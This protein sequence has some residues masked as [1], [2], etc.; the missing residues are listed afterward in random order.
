MRGINAP[1]FAI[2]LSNLSLL[3]FLAHTHFKISYHVHISHYYKIKNKEPQT[4]SCSVARC[5][6]SITA[7]S[8]CV[9][10]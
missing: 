7:R 6:T 1:F 8:R 10:S 5:R 4:L 9:A 3:L 2:S